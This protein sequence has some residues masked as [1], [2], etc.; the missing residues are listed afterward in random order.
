MRLSQL[1]PGLS[2]ACLGQGSYWKQAVYDDFYRLS[3]DLIK[4]LFKRSI[5]VFPAA[6]RVRII[7]SVAGIVT[8]FVYETL[9]A[10][11]IAFAARL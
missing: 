3:R 1:V 4:K 11:I 5:L 8:C 6:E 7:L 9:A 2:Q 10:A